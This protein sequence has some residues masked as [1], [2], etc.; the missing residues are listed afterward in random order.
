M[1]HVVIYIIFSRFSPEAFM[2]TCYGRDCRD[3]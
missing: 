3:A 1:C 2:L